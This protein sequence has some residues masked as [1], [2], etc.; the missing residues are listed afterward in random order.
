M[1]KYEYQEEDYIITIIGK[2]ADSGTWDRIVQ[3]NLFKDFLGN[4]VM[5]FVAECL[6][7]EF[8]FWSWRCGVKD[9]DHIEKSESVD[10]AGFHFVKCNDIPE[11]LSADE[12]DEFHPSFTIE[13]IKDDLYRP[14]D[15]YYP[16]RL[17]ALRTLKDK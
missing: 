4:V 9:L 1:Q 11:E 14:D 13:D 10:F 5:V 17:I 3:Y 2:W 15:L 6:W 12:K 7:N 16:K 8:L